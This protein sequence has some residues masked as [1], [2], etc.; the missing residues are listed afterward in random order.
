MTCQ[1][2]LSITTRTP[3][4][5]LWS[6]QL[7]GLR[8]WLGGDRKIWSLVG[9]WSLI[10][11]RKNSG[12]SGSI[13]LS[14]HMI[15]AASHWWGLPIFC[16]TLGQLGP[17]P[18]WLRKQGGECAMLDPSNSLIVC[19]SLHLLMF[20][21]A[22]SWGGMPVTGRMGV[23]NPYIKKASCS[24]SPQKPCA[25]MFSLAS[26]CLLAV[27]IA[28]VSPKR[29]CNPGSIPT[30]GHRLSGA[31][32]RDLWFRCVSG[33]WVPHNCRSGHVPLWNCF[34]IHTSQPVD[35]ASNR[36]LGRYHP[37]S[38]QDTAS[39]VWHGSHFIECAIDN[40]NYWE[41]SFLEYFGPLRFESAPTPML[42]VDHHDLG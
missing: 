39:E 1:L 32:P 33:S 20:L 30:L 2:L 24:L 4:L 7:G 42:G 6:H 28:R 5:P 37:C 8:D 27:C 35:Q 36:T 3:C 16:W 40:F 14:C 31:S 34:H 22:G 38:L 29:G 26:S 21:V 17:C 41:I 12:S 19:S 15:A 18:Q 23:E 25:L 9:M 11:T 10:A 13:P